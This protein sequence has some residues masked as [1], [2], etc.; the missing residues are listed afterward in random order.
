MQETWKKCQLLKK[1]KF[2]DTIFKFVRE[3]MWNCLIA[4]ISR[5]IELMDKRNTIIIQKKGKRLR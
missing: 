5:I 1:W 4:T 3:T 2:N